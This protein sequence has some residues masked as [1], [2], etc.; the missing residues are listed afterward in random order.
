MTA[1]ALTSWK[2]D[3]AGQASARPAHQLPGGAPPLPKWNLVAMGQ[4]SLTD[5][6]G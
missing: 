6:T 4:V 1:A 5:W 3:P 2:D